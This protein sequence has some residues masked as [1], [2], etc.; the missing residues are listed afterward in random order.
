VL[1]LCV[2]NRARS[3]MAEGI[4]RHLAGGRLV[5]QSAGSRPS[6]VHPLAVTVLR[7]IGI[8]IS[9]QRSK[10]V[11]E[12]E[13]EGLRWVITLCAEEECP[14]FPA[15]A[16][17]LHWPLPDPDRPGSAEEQLRAFRDVRDTLQKR[18][19]AWLP[20]VREDGG[21]ARDVDAAH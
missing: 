16:E 7:E 1:F 15:G 11:T 18:I 6:S 21:V 19:T 10:P 13:P 17:R 3:Q 14:Y 20:S 5:V 9:T 4:A 2:A 8:D 12:I